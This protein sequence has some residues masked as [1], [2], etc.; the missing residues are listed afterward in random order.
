MKTETFNI[1]KSFS[2]KYCS[3]FTSTCAYQVKHPIYGG[4]MMTPQQIKYSSGEFKN[5]LFKNI[6]DAIE[7]EIEIM[8]INNE[9]VNRLK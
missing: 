3:W 7:Y 4:S 2:L 1:P 6:K 5:K 9:F 8:G